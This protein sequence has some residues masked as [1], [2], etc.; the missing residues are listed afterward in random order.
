MGPSLSVVQTVPS[1]RRKLAPALSSPPKQ[2]DPSNKPGREPFEADWNLGQAAVEAVH[3]AID[4]AAAD[5]SLADVGVLGQLGR[6]V[7]R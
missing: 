5:Q 1:R 7:S 2:Y 4:Q 6:W 3:H